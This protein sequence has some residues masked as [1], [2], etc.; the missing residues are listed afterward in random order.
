MSL[1]Q[2]LLSQN[3]LYDSSFFSDI[4]GFESNTQMDWKET[5]NSHIFEI[6]LP[7]FTKEDVNLELRQD[8]VICIRA[9]RKEQEHEE[10]EKKML[11]WHCRERVG[12]SGVFS[13]E[14]R[15]PENSKVDDIKASMRDGVLSITVAK[16]ES[17]KKH[18]S[19]KKVVHIEQQEQGVGANNNNKGIGRFVCCKA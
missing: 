17:K 6:D 3:G 1:F 7:G 18:K 11:T 4:M 8:R 5:R 16:D 9:E 13:R 2:K 14:L 19:Y 15:L 10:E 12:T